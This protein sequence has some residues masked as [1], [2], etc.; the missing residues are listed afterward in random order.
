MK[1]I[2]LDSIN[3]NLLTNYRDAFDLEALT[4][5]Y[6]DYFHPYD[7]IL[8]DWSYGKLRLKGFYK[9]ENKSCRNL[10]SYENID[11]YIKTNCA[12]DCRYFVIEKV[13][14]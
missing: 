3:Y 1:N 10:N 14:E 7:Y 2:L 12:Y 8:G 9:K 11:N 4:T 13:I 6:T 5:R